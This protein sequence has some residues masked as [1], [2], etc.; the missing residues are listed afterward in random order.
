MLSGKTKSGFEFSISDESLD[1]ME[2]IETLAGVDKNPLLLP[3]LVSQLLGEDQKQELYNHLR[4]DGGVVPV[5]K[6]S[7]EIMEIFQSGKDTKNS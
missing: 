4:T 1:N 5:S 2:L 7:D 3:R 6:V